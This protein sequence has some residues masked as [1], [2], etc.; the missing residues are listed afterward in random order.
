M[1][2]TTTIQTN[3]ECFVDATEE[4]AA[5]HGDTCCRD[6]L[7]NQNELK[8]RLEEVGKVLRLALNNEFISALNI[9]GPK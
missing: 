8:S 1:A 2:T 7:A 3:Q 6:Q 9:C 5:A 4:F